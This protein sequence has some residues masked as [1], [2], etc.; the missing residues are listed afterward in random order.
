MMPVALPTSPPFLFFVQPP[1]QQH[2]F[3]VW[4]WNVELHTID[5]AATQRV[6]AVL[7]GF[8]RQRGTFR[9]RKDAFRKRLKHWA[10]VFSFIPSFIASS[11][12]LSATGA[13]QNGLQGKI[14]DMTLK[15]SRQRCL[16][17]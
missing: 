10:T 1:Q 9:I 17:P 7:A 5:Q 15:H 2:K 3:E 14:V 4:Y 16:K 11:I 6:A 13:E 8:L 12:S